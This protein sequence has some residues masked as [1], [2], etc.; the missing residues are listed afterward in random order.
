MSSFEFALAVL[1]VLVLFLSFALAVTAALLG[2]KHSQAEVRKLF[3]T[4][5]KNLFRLL[6]KD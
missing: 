2:N 4:A 1:I 6:S 3:Q 5:M